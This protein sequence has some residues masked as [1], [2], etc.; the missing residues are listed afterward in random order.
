MKDEF[1]KRDIEGPQV[2]PRKC[3]YVVRTML[4]LGQLDAQYM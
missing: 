4:L 2:L 1:G 3:I